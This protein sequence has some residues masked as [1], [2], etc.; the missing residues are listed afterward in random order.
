[1]T[2]HDKVARIIGRAEELGVK[3]DTRKKVKKNDKHRKVLS[4]KS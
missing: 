1:M 3:I 4:H 2:K